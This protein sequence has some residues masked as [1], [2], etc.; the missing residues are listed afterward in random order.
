[1][2]VG[3][4]DGLLRFGKFTAERGVVTARLILGF[5]FA[6]FCGGRILLG[7]WLIFRETRGGQLA[8]G[9]TQGAGREWAEQRDQA[10]AKCQQSL[11]HRP[12]LPR[13]FRRV[14]PSRFQRQ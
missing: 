12:S 11:P 1:M 13:L 10:E 3:R 4:C 14:R 2:R 7:G 6:G 8:V 9:S 5:L